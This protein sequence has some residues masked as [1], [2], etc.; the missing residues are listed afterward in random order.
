[1]SALGNPRGAS[2]LL[3]HRVGAWNAPQVL[4]GDTHPHLAPGSGSTSEVA[5]R[6]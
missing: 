5:Q 2:R 1:M 3:E 4:A 6:L